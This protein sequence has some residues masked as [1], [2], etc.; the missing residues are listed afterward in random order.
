MKRRTLAGLLAALVLLTMCLPACSHT[1]EET[2]PVEEPNDAWYADAIDWAAGQVGGSEADVS[3][4]ASGDA[5][6][7]NQ[8]IG[9]LWNMAG[10]PAA[11]HSGLFSDV[12]ADAWYAD[13]ADWAA[14][15]E[16]F[17]A[18]ET[19]FAPDQSVTRQELA[20]ILQRYAE[21]RGMDTTL[22]ADTDLHAFPDAGE[23]AEDSAAAMRWAVGVG[24]LSALS[25]GRLH[26]AEAAGRAQVAS[27]LYRW[28]NG[29][30]GYVVRQMPV[31]RESRDEQETVELRV[32]ADLPNVPY[33]GM[34][35]FWEIFMTTEMTLDRNGSE[36]VA[37]KEDGSSATID[38]KADTLYTE[39]MS[40]FSC[41]LVPEED[42]LRADVPVYY[43]DTETV[44][45][46]T[47]TK[48]DFAAYGI[49]LRGETEDVF[50]PLATL[51]DLFSDS[52]CYHVFGNGEALYVEDYIGQLYA[53][54]ARDEDV[55]Y[56]EVIYR[57][58]RP[59]DLIDFTYREMCFKVDSFYGQPGGA[60]LHEDLM[61]LGLDGALTRR[62]PAVRNALLS[63]DP[64]TYAAG[65][66]LLFQDLL[67][68]GGHTGIS[69]EL[70]D[71]NA[72]YHRTVD[73]YQQIYPALGLK[74][75]RSENVYNS[76]IAAYQARS[77]V[78]KD[79]YVVQGDTALISFDAFE[80]DAEGWTD[81]FHNG[82]PL[83]TETDTYAFVLDCLNRASRNPAVRKVV[84][85]LT[86]NGGGD[87][88]A[89]MGIMNLLTGKSYMCMDDVVT[90][91]KVRYTYDVDKNLDGEADAADAEIVYDFRFAVLTS[92]YSFSCA[93]LL[94]QLLHEN[95]ILVMGE[96]SGGGTCAIELNATADGM[97][98]RLSSRSRLVN[99]DWESIDSGV[100]VDVKL[101]YSRAGK[102]NYSDLYDLSVLSRV[103]DEYYDA[104][105]QAA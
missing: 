16:L 78:L 2:V 25:D 77:A 31:Y 79:A 27:L 72:A 12:P 88:D 46:I 23:L 105:E 53:S 11:A 33:M 92:G 87:S 48:L 45:G 73:V 4:F 102:K 93:N 101:V 55:D 82:G 98:Y 19:A 91:E 18:G 69:I 15:T 58:T 61:E 76:G 49:D 67:D 75:S 104:A 63:T 44:R 24:L 64:A 22:G 84:L 60:F 81:F 94:A 54:S 65:L 97:E 14:E 57:K 51:A 17:G 41:L 29:R 83:P 66:V 96:R 40:D 62:A 86:C 103:I 68:D 39:S 6:T 47:P 71:E 30:V 5:A 7:R 90:G 99:S 38:A 80:V 37:T 20:L 21:W 52:N 13:A 89:A 9:L 34:K 43:L 70:P 42:D 36:Y 35:A 100:P 32:Y 28:E 74:T 56:Y 59:A 3:A 10:S 95:G 50:F 8:L 1:D 85:D 26:P